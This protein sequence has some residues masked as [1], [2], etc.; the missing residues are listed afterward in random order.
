MSPRDIAGLDVDVDVVRWPD[1]E[2]SLM[3]CRG[4]IVF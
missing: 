3:F 2:L 4:E 1:L